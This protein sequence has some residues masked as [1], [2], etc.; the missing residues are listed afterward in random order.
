MFRHR[1]TKQNEQT[2][3]RH[4]QPF[5]E[6]SSRTHKTQQFAISKKNQLNQAATLMENVD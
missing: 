5:S 6:H 3:S 2:K 4:V 1:K